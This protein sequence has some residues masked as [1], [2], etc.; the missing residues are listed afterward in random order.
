MVNGP[1]NLPEIRKTVAPAPAPKLQPRTPQPTQPQEK[2][3]QVDSLVLSAQAQQLRALAAQL[4]AIPEQRPAVVQQIKVK[5][6]EVSGNSD[7]INA[8]L[9]EKLLTGS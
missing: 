5:L 2:P 7:Q 9:A 1:G 3:S 4:Q 8:K 6:T